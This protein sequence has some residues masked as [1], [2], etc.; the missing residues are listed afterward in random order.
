[1]KPND[2]SIL[3][4][5]DEAS[6]LLSVNRSLSKTGYKVDMANNGEEAIE[7][8]DKG[9]YDLVITD[10]LMPGLTGID[11]LKAAKKTNENINVI[12]LTAHGTVDSLVNAKK[13]NVTDY[14]LKPVNTSD[15]HFRVST[16]LERYELQKQIKELH[17]RLAVAEETISR[18][19]GKKNAPES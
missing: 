5:D 4:V 1:M 15:L 10:L 7:K 6:I 13:N 3:L 17:A 12:I 16:C 9:S 11:V 8:L 14:I 19:E 18:Y 2:Y